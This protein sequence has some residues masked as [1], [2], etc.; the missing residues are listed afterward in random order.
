MRQHR[1]NEVSIVCLPYVSVI[2]LRAITL[3]F[4]I[5]FT[6]KI[7]LITIESY[8]STTLCVGNSPPPVRLHFKSIIIGTLETIT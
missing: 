3:L 4:H 6:T 5:S 8:D 1:G 2:Y 7:Q